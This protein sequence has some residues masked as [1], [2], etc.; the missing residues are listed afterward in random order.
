MLE[1]MNWNGIDVI[2]SRVVAEA[3]G[4]EHHKL[5]R[6]IRTYIHHLAESNFGLSENSPS[7]SQN[8]GLSKIGSSEFFI[9]TIGG[10]GNE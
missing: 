5:M 3:V 4:K 8:L 2:D 9:E 1:L 6:D 10:T 7:Q